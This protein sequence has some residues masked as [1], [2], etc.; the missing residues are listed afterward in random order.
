MKLKVGD[1][2]QYRAFGG[3]LRTVIVDGVESDIKNGR[4][5]FDGTIIEGA[6][7]GRTVWGYDSQIVWV[8]SKGGD[9]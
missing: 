2:L 1:T 3:E 7:R 6:D 8:V 4:P 5:G 9:L